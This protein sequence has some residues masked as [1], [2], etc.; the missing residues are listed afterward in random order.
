M[1]AHP[2]PAD[3]TLD[4]IREAMAPRL[5][6]HAAF[7]GWSDAAIASAAFEFN[8][9]PDIA[10]LAFKGGPMVLIDAWIA[11]VDAEMTRRL[12]P[13][14]LAT[15]KIRERI[16]A[17]VATRLDI[18]A[19][20]REGLRRAQAVMALPQNLPAAS[21]IGWR[22]ADRMWRLAGDTATD[23]NHYTKRMTLSAV[24]LSTLVTFVN[25]DSED[26]ADTRAFL[27]RRIDNVMQFEKVK[28]QAR[29]R[30]EMMPS[31]S[32]FVGRLRYPPR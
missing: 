23:F 10:A 31:L 3:P 16:T 19:P 17:L 2:L 15:M 8:V 1:I 24:Y 7:D 5:A 25:D 30:Q 4:E 9:D 22:S 20:D 18:M 32:R 14:S 11:S 12:P 6:S 27:D 21:R 29:K 13:E 26:Y 28:A